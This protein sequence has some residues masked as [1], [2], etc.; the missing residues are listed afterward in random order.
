[1]L[2]TEDAE[3]AEQ[4]ARSPEQPTGAA[5]VRRC[6]QQAGENRGNQTEPHQP[7]GLGRHAKAR[8]LARHAQ[9]KVDESGATRQGSDGSN[10]RRQP[11][12]TEQDTHQPERPADERDYAADDPQQGGRGQ[13]VIRQCV[14]LSHAAAY[15]PGTSAEPR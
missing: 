11:A 1:M 8:G 12:Q 7:E 13:Q 2:E 9:R 10:D 6:R 14:P 5:L 4:A 15:G 3:R